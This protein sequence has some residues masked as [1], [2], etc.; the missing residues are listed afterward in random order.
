MSWKDRHLYKR[1]LNSP[2]QMTPGASCL[3]SHLSVDRCG[4]TCH[5]P[6]PRTVLP[7]RCAATGWEQAYF[8][9][10]TFSGSCSTWKDEAIISY[11]HLDFTFLFCL[12]CNRICFALKHSHTLTETQMS[13]HHTDVTG[14]LTQMSRY[15]AM[16]VDRVTQMRK[17]GQAGIQ[18]L[19]WNPTRCSLK[20]AT[21]ASQIDQLQANAHLIMWNIQPKQSKKAWTILKRINIHPAFEK[22]I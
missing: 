20:P 22:H 21:W 9:S 13:V 16:H 8:H 11:W 7:C 1:L 17:T 18:Q 10:L 14:H 3:F 12:C 19:M 4:A 2:H 5:A 6:A 15:S